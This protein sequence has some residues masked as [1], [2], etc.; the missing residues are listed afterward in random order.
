MQKAWLR[1]EAGTGLPSEGSLRAQVSGTTPSEDSLPLEGRAPTGEPSPV[2]AL[3]N[4]SGELPECKE[5]VPS[6]LYLS[7]YPAALMVIY[8]KWTLDV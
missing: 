1:E 3:L 5:C 4:D 2:K 8:Q 7:Y 6:R